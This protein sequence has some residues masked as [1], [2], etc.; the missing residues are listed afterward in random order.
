M[1]AVGVTGTLPALRPPVSKPV[2]AQ[3]VASVLL[4]VSTLD[5]PRAIDDG[6]AAS[7]A[8]MAGPTVIVVP[9]GALVAP[10]APVHTIE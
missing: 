5:P 4:Q 2:P 7:V 3:P 6:S 8:V 1:V 9:A 10:P